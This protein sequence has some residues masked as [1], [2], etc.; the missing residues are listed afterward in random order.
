MHTVA[1]EELGRDEPIP[2]EDGPVGDR[3]HHPD[4]RAVHLIGDGLRSVRGDPHH[5]AGAADRSQ[6]PLGVRREALG[7]DVV[8]PELHHHDI[9][10]RQ[11]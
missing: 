2:I 10:D 11:E 6:D 8:H 9:G 4:D 3:R 1:P 5:Q 7:V